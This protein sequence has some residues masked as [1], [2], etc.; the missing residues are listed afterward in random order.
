MRQIPPRLSTA[1]LLLALALVV[2]VLGVI[3]A[4]QQR[5][6]ERDLV[7]RFELRAQLAAGFVDAYVDE[8][9]ARQRDVAA[10]RLVSRRAERREFE[11]LVSAAGYPAA[12][13][14]D[15]DGP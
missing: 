1:G 5:R 14:L 6:S 11:A 8:L 15:A 13:L 12:V 2:G 9:A 4:A 3:V 10:L 7:D